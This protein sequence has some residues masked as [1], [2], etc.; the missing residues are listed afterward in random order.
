MISKKFTVQ[1]HKDAQKEY[2]NLDKSVLEAVNK[3][4]DELEE[5]AD[6]VGKSLGNTNT[7]K[8]SGCKEI[9]LR[10]MGIRIVFQIVEDKVNLL[11]IVYVLAIGKRDKDIVFKDA[12]KR[13]RGVRGAR[14][15]RGQR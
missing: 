5:R 13:I 14:K 11:R 3:A 10:T 12:N 15:K 4:L 7:A 6:E 9:K 2:E 1:F 8:L